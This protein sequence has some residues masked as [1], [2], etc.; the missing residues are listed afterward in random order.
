MLSHRRFKL[1]AEVKQ[2]P[3]SGKLCKNVVRYAMSFVNVSFFL[4]FTL[5]WRSDH[6]VKAYKLDDTYVVE[7]FVDS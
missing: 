6:L 1:Q 4:R 5:S 3:R 7:T 2:V